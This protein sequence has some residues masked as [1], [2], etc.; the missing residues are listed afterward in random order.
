MTKSVYALATLMVISTVAVAN[1]QGSA[2]PTPT[3]VEG[4]QPQQDDTTGQQDKQK[5]SN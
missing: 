2:Q 4:G 1:E 3:S 5:G